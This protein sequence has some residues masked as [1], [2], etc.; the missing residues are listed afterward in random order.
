MERED[1]FLS[2][3]ISTATESLFCRR[4][5]PIYEQINEEN[6]SYDCSVNQDSNLCPAGIIG[7][8]TVNRESVYSATICRVFHFRFPRRGSFSLDCLGQKTVEKFDSL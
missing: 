4:M 2:R 6:G 8:G 7:Q 3:Q 5:F 1:T